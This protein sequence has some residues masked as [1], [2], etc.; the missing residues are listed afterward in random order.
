MRLAADIEANGLLDTVSKFH[1]MVAID[2]DSRFVHKFYPDQIDQAIDFLE[3]ADQVIMHNGIKYDHPAL[4]KLSGRK[5]RKDN[6]TD[7]LVLSRLIYSNLKDKDYP[8]ITR[9]KKWAAMEAQIEKLESLNDPNHLPYLAGLKKKLEISKK[10]VALPPKLYGSHSL[11]AW[12]YRLG[13]N[14][15]EFA[16]ETDWQTF[17]PEMLN[18]C[19]QDVWVT[20]DLFEL[21]ESKAYAETAIKLEHDVAWLMAK[22][23]QN[24][25]YFDTKA[26][27]VLEVTLRSQYVTLETE[28]KKV[29]GCWFQK[30]GETT[31]KR[32][33]N[34]KDPVR[35]DLTQGASYTKIKLVEYNPASRQHTSRCLKKLYDWKPSVFTDNGDP[36]ID[37]D[38]LGKLPY[39][40]AQLLARYFML[41]KRLGQLIDGNQGWLKQVTTEGFIHGS[42]NP[43]GAVT[44]RATHAYPNVAQVPSCKAEYG[45]NCRELFTVPSGWLLFG[46]DASGLELRC[47]AHFM[48]RYD[49]GEYVSVVLDGD[50][51]TTNMNAAGLTI[52]DQ[53]KTFI[54]AFLYGGGD[55]VV[56]A[57]VKPQGTE[58]EQKKVGRRLKK[59]FL[60]N[61]PAI[62]ALRNAVKAVAEKR[63]Y[64]K[65]LDNRQVH[66][67]SAHAA[68]NTLL[69]SAGALICKY[70]I[71]E[72]ERIAQSRGLK[73]GWDGDYAFCAWVHDEVQ[74][75]VRNEEVAKQF[76]EIVDLAIKE[77]EKAFNFRCPLACDSAVGT[78]W[79]D[80][81]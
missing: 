32:T 1:C 12:G 8:L 77:T 39:P 28:L 76:A 64:V 52:R 81:H 63:G 13:N 57:I 58:D 44:G 26:A 22:Q 34:Y 42:V 27:E 40:E 56:G 78:S 53:A 51:H 71:V 75:A 38:V 45:S 6:W 5:I 68:L 79:K 35:A 4:E 49:D 61:T 19:E 46:S 20:L 54:Y 15:G 24:G 47:L 36:K 14:K 9:W 74:I 65:G 37:D 3:Q 67:R 31:P 72:I 66:I 73:H 29:F 69:Q 43:N 11:K 48:A 2:V 70:W 80:T 62:R 50:V 23:E 41:S 59:K 10:K 21:L 7:T 17:S 25:F 16:E 33:L 55:Q 60:D 18:Y 30:V